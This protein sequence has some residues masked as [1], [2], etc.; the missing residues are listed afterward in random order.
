MIGNLATEGDLEQWVKRLLDRLGVRAG[1]SRV[2]VFTVASLPAAAPE[3]EGVL[4]YVRDGAAG[5]KWRGSN[6]SSWDTLG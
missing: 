1:A 2:P 6:G 3:N 4:V 5:T